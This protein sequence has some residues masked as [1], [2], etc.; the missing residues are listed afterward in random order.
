MDAWGTGISSND[1]YADV[2][3]HFF[4][5]YNDGLA[6]AEIS[7]RLIRESWIWLKNLLSYD[8]SYASI[9]GRPTSTLKLATWVKKRRRFPILKRLNS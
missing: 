5:L 3:D 9:N 1:T 2:Y 8:D 7:T 4:E 6:V